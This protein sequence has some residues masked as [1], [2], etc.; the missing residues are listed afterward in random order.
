LGDIVRGTWPMEFGSRKGTIFSY[1][2]NNYWDT[3]WPAGQGGEV[4]FRYVLGSG[5]D[6]NPVTLGQLGWDA[7]SPL[8]VNEIKTQDKAINPA[9]RLEAARGSFLTVDQPNVVLVTWKL[10]EDS[11]GSVLRFLE[12][13]GQAG[14]VNVKLPLLNLQSA[15]RC[16]AVEDNQ[17]SLP[18][19][20]HALQ[21]SFTPHQIVTIRVQ[22]TPA[23]K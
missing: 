13:A 8:E 16:N 23:L 7:M 5:K 3:N 19:L 17:Q 20:P 2:M 4:R 10:A 15:W 1:I 12:V 18:V 14:S 22:G 21:F 11:Q 9:R 6:L